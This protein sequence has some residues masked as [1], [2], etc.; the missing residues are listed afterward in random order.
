[1]D[2]LDL[3]TSLLTS[4]FV[5]MSSLLIWAM[6][7][8]IDKI[9]ED[10]ENLTK[11]IYQLIARIDVMNVNYKNAYQDLKDIEKRTLSNENQIAKIKER[12][13]LLENKN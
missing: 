11:E 10:V 7:K 2:A 13:A 1:M 6:K 4:L 12:L 8:F 9:K 3:I 5:I